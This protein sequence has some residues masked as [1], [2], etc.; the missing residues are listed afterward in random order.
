LGEAHAR[1]G[2]KGVAIDSYEMA[3]ELDP[4]NAH[5]AGELKNLKRE[6]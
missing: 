5:A 3:V 6:P 1:N 2:D 4:T